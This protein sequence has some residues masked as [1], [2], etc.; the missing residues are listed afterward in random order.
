MRKFFIKIKVLNPNPCVEK[1]WFEKTLAYS[2]YL[3]ITY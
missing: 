1:I 3:G 2:K